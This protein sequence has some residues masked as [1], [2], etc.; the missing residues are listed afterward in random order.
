M[1]AARITALLIT[2]IVSG[3]A[4]I[5]DPESYIKDWA[6]NGQLSQLVELPATERAQLLEFVKKWRGGPEQ[7]WGRQEEC[8]FLL[9]DPLAR[10]KVITQYREDALTGS[11]ISSFVLRTS[12]DPEIVTKIA[13]LLWREEGG[14][15]APDVQVSNAAY[16]SAAVIREV[17]VKVMDFDPRVRVWIVSLKSA[18]ES[19]ALELLRDWWKAN[20]KAFRE[21]RYGDVKPGA[22]PPEDPQDTRMAE[23]TQPLPSPENSA[24]KQNTQSGAQVA[25][26]SGSESPVWLLWG[27]GAL[28]FAAAVATLILWRR[29]GL[30]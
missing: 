11:F 26:T 8:E 3:H 19:T 5:A 1:N 7:P 22:K 16:L 23:V 10:D 4:E 17:A 30:R 24:R 12:K 6:L 27:G 20:E 9:G 18:S 21:K 25:V 2:L 13:D 14:V 15:N 29:K 28:A